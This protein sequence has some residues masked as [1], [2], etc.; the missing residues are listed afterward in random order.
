MST[1]KQDKNL[2]ELAHF[3]LAQLSLAQLSRFGTAKACSSLLWAVVK[4]NK[5]SGYLYYP[6][7]RC[8]YEL[9]PCTG[10]A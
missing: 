5:I 3:G 1:Q 4:R 10:K 7:M 8:L 9:Q 6:S 2:P